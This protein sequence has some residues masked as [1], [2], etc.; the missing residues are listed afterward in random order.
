MRCLP[1]ADCKI[2]SSSLVR[3]ELGGLHGQLHTIC[4]ASRLR[5]GHVQMYLLPTVPAGIL[6]GRLRLWR[7]AV[8]SAGP[9]AGKAT[10][11][12]QS[13]VGQDLLVACCTKSP[14]DANAGAL[15]GK[16]TPGPALALGS[17]GRAR[18]GRTRWLHAG[19]EA[20]QMQMRDR[21][22]ART[23]WGLH[24]RWDLYR[25]RCLPARGR[26]GPGV[27]LTGTTAELRG[28]CTALPA[29]WLQP[30]W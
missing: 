7:L 29:A 23:R 4:R 11:W 25:R 16:T 6:R 24:W 19:Q 18:S 26:T 22:A 28:S 3:P 8:A 21:G 5:V 15:G 2:V 14:A 9:S 13:K 12:R 1:I 17:G 20:L 10:A 30:C 27:T